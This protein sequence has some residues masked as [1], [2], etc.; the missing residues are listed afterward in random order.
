MVENDIKIF[1]F[2]SA[3]LPL[4][5]I[6]LLGPNQA[7]VISSF[8][9]YKPEI[10]TNHYMLKSWEKDTIIHTG[11]QSVNV[12]FYGIA[13][14]YT[15][16]YLSWIMK[17]FIHEEQVPLFGTNNEDFLVIPRESVEIALNNIK[18][19]LLHAYAKRVNSKEY[20]TQAQGVQIRG[21][22][23][24]DFKNINDPDEIEIAREHLPRHVLFAGIQD[25]TYS[26]FEVPDNASPHVRIL[27]EKI[28]RSEKTR[29]DIDIVSQIP[30]KVWKK[31]MSEV[32]ELISKWEKVERQKIQDFVENELSKKKLE[33]GE[34]KTT[35]DFTYDE[36]ER[37]KELQELQNRLKIKRKTME[38]NLAQR[39]K[40]KEALERAVKE[41]ET[42]I[43]FNKIR[44]VERIYNNDL[45][46]SKTRLIPIFSRLYGPLFTA[47][48]IQVNMTT[49]IFYK[50][51][52]PFKL[53]LNVG[54][55]T[56]ATLILVS[57]LSSSLRSTIARLTLNE[58]F[59]ER[60]KLM[61]MLR[62]ELDDVAD[63]W[64][65]DITSVAIEEIFLEDPG[66]QRQLDDRREMELHGEKR[67]EDKRVEAAEKEIQ[68][69]QQA[70]RIVM[71]SQAEK[72]REL[73]RFQQAIERSKVELET[74]QI[75]AQTLLKEKQF[76]A[77]RILIAAQGEASELSLQSKTLTPML[78]KRELIRNL[79]DIIEKMTNSMQTAILSPEQYIDMITGKKLYDAI[80][81]MFK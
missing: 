55:E 62:R 12:G 36:T 75:E 79:P 44:A 42:G 21:I 10:K 13:G 72:E 26:D 15:E 74:R 65:I 71:E 27:A 3:L 48:K 6:R 2:I 23:P 19:D 25:S 24:Y 30:I 35:E 20:F 52:D 64:G 31:V 77:E 56:R 70:E 76:E 54:S 58:V 69:R 8:G 45:V 9:K 68:G 78:L 73:N 4:L 34:E 47:E 16:I 81:N 41:I 43:A 66:F 60:Q 51:D 57:K 28:Y 63:K 39:K 49:S 33:M 40:E 53:V 50:I 29:L 67:I 46:F 11:Q 59:E 1:K 37:L 18:E 14:R 80:E 32:D 5:D 17:T 61:E 22:V 38:S 7:A